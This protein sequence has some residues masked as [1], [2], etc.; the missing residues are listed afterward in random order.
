MMNKIPNIIKESVIF[1]LTNPILFIPL[2]L[3]FIYTLVLDFVSSRVISTFSTQTPFYIW[4][5]FTLILS[6]FVFSYALSCSINLSLSNNKKSNKLSL[7]RISFKRL[8]SIAGILIIIFLAYN[9]IRFIAHYGAFITGNIFSLSLQPA[10]IIFYI[11][12]FAGLITLITFLTFS[13]FFCIKNKLPISKSIFSS[14]SFVRNNYLETLIVLVIFFIIYQLIGLITNQLLSDAI[15][16]II[17]TPILIL[18]LA[19]MIKDDL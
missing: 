11:I 16:T 18:I 8:F 10:Q 19:S 7:F 9:L 3:V 13:S 1:S 17:I 6:L 2:V 15:N 5:G 12:Y 14:I 4:L